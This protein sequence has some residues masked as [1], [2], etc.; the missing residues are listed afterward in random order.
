LQDAYSSKYKSALYSGVFEHAVKSYRRDA[1]TNNEKNEQEE[2]RKELNIPD[3]IR[4]STVEDSSARAQ[5]NLETLPGKVLERARVFHRYIQYLS[6]SEHGAVVTTDLKLMLDDISRAEKL[7]DK[8]KDEILQDE[9]AKHVSVG[10]GLVAP[11]ILMTDS[12]S[13]HSVCS[14]LRVSP[15]SAQFF[16]GS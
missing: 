3:V 8:M 7:D 2:E 6:H 5:R 12:L 9:E 16:F 13:R 10:Q 1:K 11:S 15:L 14:I 4:P